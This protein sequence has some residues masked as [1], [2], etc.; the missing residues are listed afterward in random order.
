MWGFPGGPENKEIAEKYKHLFPNALKVEAEDCYMC[1]AG[2]FEIQYV[3]RAF[4]K[5]RENIWFRVMRNGFI[6]D[7]FYNHIWID[8]VDN[9]IL[10]KA[11]F[12]NIKDGVTIENAIKHIENLVCIYTSN[13]FFKV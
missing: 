12:F 5:D 8:V 11:Q 1:S 7:A 9:D 2:D 10:L 4:Y 3:V 6:Y 13:T